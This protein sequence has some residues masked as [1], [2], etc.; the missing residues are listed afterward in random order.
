MAE[1]YKIMANNLEN[2][3]L[4][5]I[6]L[7]RNINRVIR[8]EKKRKCPVKAN[9]K[10]KDNFKCLIESVGI[11]VRVIIIEIIA[12]INANPL[13]HMNICFELKGALVIDGLGK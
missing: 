11:L 2:K 4:R 5:N 7:I 9:D 13:N 1:P 8:T 12:F 6:W 10:N 3:I